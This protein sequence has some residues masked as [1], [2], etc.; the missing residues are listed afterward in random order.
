VST[1]YI[2]Q[3]FL[4]RKIFLSGNEPSQSMMLEKFAY[5]HYKLRISCSIF[6][7]RNTIICCCV[8]IFR[9]VMSTTY[10]NPAVKGLIREFKLRVSRN[11]KHGR[12]ELSSQNFR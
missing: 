5:S 2:L 4:P 11:G 1:N 6:T 12:F 9:Q 7:V 10:G 3:I 8:H